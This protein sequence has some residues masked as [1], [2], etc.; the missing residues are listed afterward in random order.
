MK[1][2]Q[3]SAVLFVILE[4]LC[5]G[6]VL[7][8]SWQ[9]A[10]DSFVEKKAFVFD[11]FWTNSFLSYPEKPEASKFYNNPIY[12]RHPLL[13]LVH[14]GHN[15]LLN[16]RQNI[17]VLHKNCTQTHKT[18]NPITHTKLPPFFIYSTLQGPEAIPLTSVFL[19]P[20]GSHGASLGSRHPPL[21]LWTD[22][23]VLHIPCSGN[24]TAV[25]FAEDTGV[26]KSQ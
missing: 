15:S 23:S 3:Q 25:F 26:I 12:P 22:T 5:K 16:D 13:S 11:E 18:R 6:K 24:N 14:P 9:A 2:D 19:S 4:F 20:I 10:T 8:A 21:M 17:C 7:K 1:T